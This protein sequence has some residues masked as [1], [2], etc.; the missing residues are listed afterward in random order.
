MTGIAASSE[1]ASSRSSRFHRA[2]IARDL[3]R[4]RVVAR[5]KSV[6]SH[7]VE[8]GVH[9]RLG[10][11]QHVPVAVQHGHDTELTGQC[12]KRPDGPLAVGSPVAARLRGVVTYE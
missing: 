1:V 2:D 11:G 6:G 9:L 12:G 3:D 4:W 7:D 8:R 10:P 5:R